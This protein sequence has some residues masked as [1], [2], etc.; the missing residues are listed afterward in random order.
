MDRCHNS[1][2]AWYNPLM[3][4]EIIGDAT[5]YLG[6]C[7]EVLPSL[8]RADVIVTDPPYG[9]G[10]TN[11]GGRKAGQFYSATHKAEWDRWDTGWIKICPAARYAIFCPQQ[12]LPELAQCF[13][14]WWLRCYIKSNPRPG[15]GGADA[16]SVEPIMCSPN[17]KHGGAQHFIA[18]NGD[19][20]FHPTQ[21][22]LPVMTWLVLGCSSPGDMILDPFMG[23]GTTGLAALLLGRAFTG[24]EI[25]PIY[26]D[27]A[28]RRIEAA[29]RQGDLLNKLPPADDPA[30]RRM[31][32]LFAQSEF[33]A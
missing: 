32:D 7:R 33:G 15:L 6:D 12:R 31:A 26:F 16:P 18:Y 3:R 8:R 29:Q 11:G 19:N 2:P 23:S 9:T 5:L 14:R 20:K 4:T 10:W 17:V 22:P 24:I 28:C 30:D 27:A 13:D 1:L 25:E 21:K